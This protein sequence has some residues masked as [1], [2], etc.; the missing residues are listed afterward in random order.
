MTQ[1]QRTALFQLIADVILIVWFLN[2][3]FARDALGD[4]AGEAGLA[5]LGTMAL[6]FILITIVVGIVV[7]IL[8]NVLSGVVNM[9]E[10]PDQTIDERDTRIR[11]RGEEIA[12][13]ATGGSF[14][15]AL[16][17]LATGYGAVTMV[18]TLFLGFVTSDAIGNIAKLVGY[19]RG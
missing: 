10:L 11:R 14:V 1:E 16:I 9:G 5:A 15:I 18:A 6:K 7:Q 12:H 13:W 8:G 2:R 19:M 17:L 3:F 4:F